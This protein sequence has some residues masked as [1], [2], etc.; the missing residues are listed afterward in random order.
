MSDTLTRREFGKLF[1]GA[2]VGVMLYEVTEVGDLPETYEASEQPLLSFRTPN[3]TDLLCYGVNLIKYKKYIQPKQRYANGQRQP[4]FLIVQIPGLSLHEYAHYSFPPSIPTKQQRALAAGP[5]F[6]A[7]EL[8]PKV[9]ADTRGRRP[10]PRM[11]CTIASVFNWD[12]MTRFRLL[13]AN[14]VALD[15]LWPCVRTQAVDAAI[16]PASRPQLA[17]FSYYKWLL[18]KLFGQPVGPGAGSPPLTVL[19][20]PTGSF[21][22]LVLRQLPAPQGKAH[23]PYLASN[24]AAQRGGLARRVVWFD[25]GAQQRW[26]T[27][28]EI[29]Q[30]ELRYA[31]T[32]RPWAQQPRDGYDDIRPTTSAQQLAKLNQQRAEQLAA[33]QDQ[34]EATAGAAP[35]PNLVVTPATHAPGLR[36]LAYFR[37]PA[38]SERP[39]TEVCQDVGGTDFLLPANKDHEQL[40]VLNQLGL[41][42]CEESP[43]ATVQ[44]TDFRSNRYDIRLVSPLV[45]GGR[46]ATFK[47]EYKNYDTARIPGTFSIVEYVHHIQD[48]N[49]N[50]I[51]IAN[52]GVLAPVDLKAIHVRQASRV[53]QDG[54]SYMRYE[55]R[56]ELVETW[57]IFKRPRKLPDDEAYELFKP[58][59]ASASPLEAH[60]LQRFYT[61]VEAVVVK[62]NIR[63]VGACCPHF[64]PAQ[65]KPVTPGSFPVGQCPPDSI[66]LP[67][68]YVPLKL[69]FR[70]YDADGLLLKESEH[71]VQFISRE[72][73][74]SPKH[75]RELLTDPGSPHYLGGIQDERL[76]IPLGG[77]VVGLTETAPAP[78]LVASL[79]PAESQ[80]LNKPNR[81]ATAWAEWY[82]HLAKPSSTTPPGANVFDTARHLVYAQIRRYQAVIDHV[83]GVAGQPL[84]S[85]L[86]YSPHYLKY[87]FEAS[88][89]VNLTGPSP[90]GNDRL[91]LMLQHTQDFLQD[92]VLDWR[93]NP[94]TAN[95]LYAGLRGGMSRI[96][97]VFKDVGERLGGLANPDPVLEQ[98]AGI[99]QNLALPPIRKMQGV[100]QDAS[101][102]LD[103]IRRPLDIL[104][105]DAAE[106][107]G[108]KIVRLLRETLT[109]GDTPQFL[110]QQFNAGADALAT[111]INSLKNPIIKLALK[112]VQATQVQV[113]RLAQQLTLAEQALP[114]LRDELRLA[115]TTLL[116]HVPDLDKVKTLVL[117]LFD[118][119]RF[120][121]VLAAKG[122]DLATYIKR[123]LAP[124]LSPY[125]RV[126]WLLKTGQVRPTELDRYQLLAESAYREQVSNLVKRLQEVLQASLPTGSAAR[127]ELDAAVRVLLAPEVLDRLHGA[128]KRLILAVNTAAVAAEEVVA[129]VQALDQLGT[130][131]A[132][133]WTMLTSEQLQAVDYLLLRYTELYET[134]RRTAGVLEP[135]LKAWEPVV[136]LLRLSTRT[137]EQYFKQRQ[138][139]ATEAAR[140]LQQTSWLLATDTIQNEVVT[141]VSVLVK[142]YEV[143]AL[144]S[145]TQ[146]ALNALAKLP[147]FVNEQY[148]KAREKLWQDLQNRPEYQAAKAALLAYKKLAGDIKDKEA[149][150]RTLADDFRREAEKQARGFL[151]QFKKEV[152]SE[153]AQLGGAA[154]QQALEAYE[155][156]RRFLATPMRKDLA[157]DWQTADFV[158]VNLGFVRFI[159]QQDPPTRLKL[160]SSTSVIL[161]ASQLP[162]VTTSVVARTETS[163]TNFALSFL[164]VLTIDFA[165]IAFQ[166][167]S[168][169]SSDL[170]VRI[171]GVRFEGPLTFI[172]ALQDTLAGLVDA[173]LPL[174][175]DRRV[176]ISY[177]SPPFD[178]GAPGFIFLN[179]SFGISLDLFFD[180]RPMRATFRLAQPENKAMV[181]AGVYGGAFFM[182]LTVTPT[183]GVV[184]IEMA[185][186]MGAL[187]AFSLGP[188]RGFVRFM[189]GLYYLKRESLVVMEGYFIAE[190]ILRV[191][192]LQVSARL[193]MGIRSYGG[194]VEGKCT[195]SYSVKIGFLRKSFSSTYVKQIAGT[196]SQQASNE[197]AGGPSGQPQ[198]AA[199]LVA[200]AG[201]DK[202]ALTASNIAHRVGEATGATSWEDQFQ[203]MTKP[204]FSC[205][206]T[207][208][209]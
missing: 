58:P 76:L 109:E 3:G 106:L 36:L 6:L 135:E 205:F 82:Y 141:L 152:D 4:S 7:F 128:G 77:Q 144:L 139:K 63:P 120:E 148:D 18:N 94:L 24:G 67:Q 17:D 194:Y 105:G 12:D 196:A 80:S 31:A 188:V 14:D 102:A 150:L 175:Q 73:F 183:Q 42:R 176:T 147:D 145:E 44:D 181:A 68:G 189:A 133:A 45:L 59:L 149:A 33:Y 48:G 39:A 123:E 8:W 130:D 81:L 124:D 51:R 38:T 204:D 114:L 201:P 159:P 206:C 170:D 138:A 110:Q 98:V 119:K 126:A 192:F 122:A 61:R 87:K 198:L 131:F 15:S 21:M 132:A 92:K 34:A 174:I 107:F 40:L 151:A 43:P 60:P 186:E 37:N 208:Y 32:D 66:R 190:G 187:L 162:A 169:R 115:Y 163:V 166:A 83:Q 57:K 167:G 52:I 84:A 72:C 47:A 111:T 118:A 182:S 10:R 74:A 199:A 197:P 46:G 93:G 142:E 207:T 22:G 178:A 91:L 165:Y 153:L 27:V 108:I 121:Q 191:W 202:N 155:Q 168:G 64:W 85:L 99:G 70:Y 69:R 172:Q 112:R 90:E 41:R 20:V 158:D 62:H 195:V 54:R 96:R 157:Y 180:R 30:T 49:D 154:L 161:D 113:D 101:T 203:V 164:G 129:L 50:F 29:W 11:A 127:T 65:E 125:V 55:E 16:D 71:A 143:S 140:T 35:P 100:L 88:D 19:E 173:F 116:S 28:S 75:L 146:S 78:K 1:G 193:Y 200:M 117:E 209:F 137:Q 23:Q 184:E 160:H 171:R 134:A 103:T 2:L 79:V 177:Q 9:P 156:A 86:E 136:G 25:N 185:L 53:A 56:I 95:P 104:N 5:S 89:V 26:R 179:L 13:A 97:S